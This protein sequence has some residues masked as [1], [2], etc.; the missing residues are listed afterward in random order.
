MNNQEVTELPSNYRG[1]STSP[2]NAIVS[3]ANVIQD[4]NGNI[5]LTGSLPFATDYSVDGTSTVNVVNN[6]PSRNM[7]PSSEMLSEFKISAI[8][9][10]AEFASTGD[11]TVTT[12]SGGNAIHGSAFEYLQNRDLDATT[13][14]SSQKQAKSW[15]TFGGSLSGPVVIPKIYNGHD[16]TFF[17]I[18]SEENRKPG[19]TLIVNNVPTAA[20]D[21]GNLNGVA[22]KTAVDPFS[23][24]VPFPNNQIPLSELNPVAEKLLT[25]YYPLPNYNSGSTTG[26]YRSLLPLQNETN[27]YDIRLDQYIKS[28]NQLFGRWTWKNI[29]YQGISRA[30]SIAQT[31]P[32]I[33]YN[34]TDKNLIISDSYTI[35]SHIVNE[36]RFGLSFLDSSQSFPYQGAAVVANLGLTGLDLSNAGN[37]GGFPGFNFSS[38]TGFSRIGHGA[39]GPQNSVTYQYTDNASWIKGKHTIKVGI[40]YRDVH[41]NRINNFGGSDEFGSMTFNGGF[42]GNAFANLLLGLPATNTVY[43]IG[44]P[45]D[46]V[47]NHFATYAQDEWR[48]SRS[49][50]ISFGLR[51][52]IQPPFT[53][54]NG[55]IANFLPINGG[56]MVYPNIA[57]KVLPPAASVLYT[58]NDCSLTP[59]PNPALPCSPV[60][61][62][63]QAGLPQGLRQ[64]YFGDYNPRL[65]IAYRPFSNDKTVFRAGIGLFTVPTLGGVAYQMTG[66]AST[67]SPTYVNAIVNGQPLFRLPSVAY[68]NGGLVPS[69]VG[70]YTFDVAQ[71]TDYKD[72]QSAQ[73]NVTVERQFLGSW[74]GRASYIGE[75]SYR[76]PVQIDQNQCHPT[77][78]GPCVAPFPQWG[79]IYT[80][81]NVGFGNYQDLELQV[82]HRLASGFYMQATYDWA[83]DLS[84]ANNDG[85]VGFGAEQGNGSP[86]GGPLNDRFST[87]NER[88]ND[89]G[90]RRSRFLATGIY[91]LPFGHGRQFLAKSNGFV[92]GV[93]GG[94]QLSAIIL[95]QTGPFMTAWDSN[96]ADSAANLNEAERSSA[97]RPDQIGNCNL[98]NPGPNGWFNLNAFALTPQG[99]GRI[100]N[101]G[102]GNCV[103]PPTTTVSGG[104]SKNFP[105]REHLRMRFE[106]TF[107]NIL[108]HPN[109]IQPPTMD[110][111]SPSAFGVTQTVQ[112]A[113]NGGNRVGQLSLRLDF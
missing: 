93:L 51:W 76:L 2:L 65:G 42:S 71:T 45:I 100:G 26:D 85:P 61:T 49:L 73:W 104:L 97:V 8:S 41:Y 39:I 69:D 77:P 22:G 107:T 19:S 70:T 4:Q 74:T 90:P 111:S 10:N 23:N 21:S 48:A 58:I 35:T 89:P 9:N 75:N 50:T 31:L 94:W 78:H 81:A 52:E 13:Y 53:E 105:I 32:P 103:G 79:P 62:A 82:S 84:N 87:R 38:G 29:P 55:N 16:R 27:G 36:F 33:T 56:E 63:S 20:M 98:S 44:P 91:L 67:N 18:D 106:A 25:T 92:N 12:K 57:A 101:E 59:L 17:F 72:P 30:N 60:V 68:G 1:A 109:F 110:V 113:E 96:P 102:I 83:K 88:G 112:T 46:Q 40:D 108:N 14:G 95:A 28:K 47:S 80:L 3:S 34:E 24:G 86:A 99:A 7:Y 11:V 37:Q 66:T 6:T 15:N 43:D 64:T 54:K 5:A